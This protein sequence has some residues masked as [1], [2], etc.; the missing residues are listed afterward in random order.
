MTPSEAGP[1]AAAFG[2]GA[3]LQA[4][5]ARYLGRPGPTGA[6]G[7]LAD[8]QADKA[9]SEAEALAWA[10]MRQEVDRL[11]VQ[12]ARLTDQV[13][14]YRVQVDTL[15][16]EVERLRGVEVADKRRI[17]ELEARVRE[18]ERGRRIPS[19]LDGDDAGGER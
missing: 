12:V 13:T 2:V 11:V 9:R 7:R 5:A 1:L 15:T 3:I 16:A 10:N 4:I 19:A 6:D 8:A 18:L 17:A 14:T